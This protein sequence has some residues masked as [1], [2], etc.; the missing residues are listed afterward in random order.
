MIGHVADSRWL[1]VCRIITKVDLCL[2]W[3]SYHAAMDV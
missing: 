2:E 1:E 3:H